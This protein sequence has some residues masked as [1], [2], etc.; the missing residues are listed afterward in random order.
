MNLPISLGPGLKFYSIIC[1]EKD[2]RRFLLPITYNYIQ[3]CKTIRN[4]ELCDRSQF[5][6]TV[7]H[8]VPHY[9]REEAR[10]EAWQGEKRLDGVAWFSRRCHRFVHRIS[11]PEALGKNYWSIEL[12]LK[13]T[14]I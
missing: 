11:S 2:L 10:K 7:R 8:L 6:L 1:E 5:A 13:R 12:L 3:E 9:V 14:E 4:C